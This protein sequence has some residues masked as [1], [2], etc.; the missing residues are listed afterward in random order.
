MGVWESDGGEREREW[1]VWRR[2]RP[3]KGELGGG[4]RKSER[5]EVGGEEKAKVGGMGQL[6][7][8]W[9]SIVYFLFLFLN[10]KWLFI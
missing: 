3:D 8:S 2:E 6:L 1:Q 5:L 10:P 9:W 4:W 7:V